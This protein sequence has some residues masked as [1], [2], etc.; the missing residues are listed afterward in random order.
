MRCE[1]DWIKMKRR[2]GFVL[3]TIGAA[4]LMGTN[5][6]GLGS[7][8]FTNRVEQ[9][10][11]PEGMEELVNSTNR[12]HGFFVNAADRFFFSGGAEEFNS[13]LQAY[14]KIAGIDGHEL[15]LH[16]GAG[17]AKSPWE[18][19]PRACDWGLLGI[20][21]SW[22]KV[23]ELSGQGTNSAGTMKEAARDTNYVLRV[24]FWTGGKI[25]FEQIKVPENVK[26]VKD[27][28]TK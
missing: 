6:Y 26:V 9:P 24:D 25:P 10:A 7:D 13:F 22:L 27:D 4:I 20:P 1:T 18:K 11:W 16:A 23:G 3:A 5:A 21:K 12:V 19:A 28:K 8:Y 15:I 17:D 14:S 2:F